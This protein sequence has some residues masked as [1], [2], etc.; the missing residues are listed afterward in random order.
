MKNFPIQVYGFFKKFG[1]ESFLV[2]VLKVIDVNGV[3][4][5]VVWVRKRK[6]RV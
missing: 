2:K 3:A 5:K 1:T 6:T 4:N